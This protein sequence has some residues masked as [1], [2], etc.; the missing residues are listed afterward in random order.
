MQKN[1]SVEVATLDMDATLVPS[2]KLEAR[3]SYK[4]FTGYQP[5]NVYWHE[6]AMVA[7]SEFRDG[8]VPAG[9]D[10]KRVFEE[11]LCHLPEGVERVYLRSDSAGYKYELLDYCHEGFHPRFG[12][13]EF[14]VS[15]IASKEF[16]EAVSEVG[17]RDWQPIYVEIG[18][19]KVASGQEWA[20]VCYVPSRKGYRLDAPLYRYLAV[21]ETIRQPVFD[22]FDSD[23]AYDF[24]T[25]VC[26]GKRYRIS[27]YVTNMDWYGEELIHWARKRCGQ[28]EHI[29]SVMKNDFCGG[30][31]PCA[32]FGA[33][34]CWW[35]VMI[36]ALN[37]HAILKELVFDGSWRCR[38]MKSVRFGIIHIAA[39]VANRSR[40]LHIVLSK[41]EAMVEVLIGWRK[42]ILGLIP[43]P[44][45]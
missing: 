22:A 16:K 40:Q 27:G 10:L 2:D 43:L 17:E 25:A 42:K 24:P 7:H 26:T 30:K 21:R 28:S 6:Q 45:G 37:L 1:R 14:C 39:R 34:A 33:N 36:I 9:Y 35:M 3:M 41:G 44:S 13:I 5:L 31:L 15:S 4:G 29:H 32:E 23:E 18:N 38:R 19:Y 11:S 12:R 20:E 8:N